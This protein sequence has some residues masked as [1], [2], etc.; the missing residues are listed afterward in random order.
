MHLAALYVA[1]YLGDT[2]HL[3]TEQH[4]AY[5]LLLMAMWR[6]GGLAV[7]RPGQA[8]PHGG[9][10]PG[11]MGEDPDDVLDVLSGRSGLLSHRRVT[12]ELKKSQ[13][14]SEAVAKLAHAARS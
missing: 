12:S 2:R 1:D 4:G 9:P 3:T 11:A 5:M 6:A 13:R 10:Q 14:T 8:G 7:R